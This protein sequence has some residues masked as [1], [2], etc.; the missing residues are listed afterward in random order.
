MKCGARN[1]KPVSAITD[2]AK[3]YRANTP[4]CRPAG[5]KRCEL[6]GSKRFLVVDHRDGNE[7]N[8][9]PANLRWLCRSCNTV[10]GSQMAMAGKG[11]R[12]RQYNP[13]PAASLLEVAE[14]LQL[15]SELA[16]RRRN[17]V[18]G[19]SSAAEYLAAIAVLEGSLPGDPVT[20]RRL[21]HNTPAAIRAE[22]QQQAAGHVAI[23]AMLGNPFGGNYGG[24]TFEQ[25]AAAFAGGMPG[26]EARKVIREVR[27]SGD[28]PSYQREVWR[29]RRG[30]YGPS[31]WPS[32]GSDVPF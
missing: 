28:L 6:C 17:P 16:P 21:V 10:E 15:A 14:G 30:R 23:D 29:R 9:S 18:F 32:A 20:A 24:Y 31:G 13:L 25:V 1:R 8:G 2:R 11:T 3:R 7:A 4:E 27:D 22:A 26:A 12:T 19:A 5:P